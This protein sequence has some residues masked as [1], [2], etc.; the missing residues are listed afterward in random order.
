MAKKIARAVVEA[1]YM[2]QKLETTHEFA[3]LVASVIEKDKNL[4]KLGRPTHS[5][6]KTFQALR[7]FIN[8]E[9]NELHR[10][11]EL[12]HQ[13]LKV[14][15]TIVALTFHSLEVCPFSSAMTPLPLVVLVLRVNMYVVLQDRIVKRHLIGIEMNEPVA[16]TISQKYLNSLNTPS[17][18]DVENV[19]NKKWSVVTKHV[20]SPTFYEVKMNPRSRSAKLRCATKN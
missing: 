13:L 9:L 12:A 1:R 16:Q 6:T 5:A 20:V 7:I 15:G 4:D 14:N 11:M 18:E 2:F 8:D 3:H 17:K 10:G 19:F